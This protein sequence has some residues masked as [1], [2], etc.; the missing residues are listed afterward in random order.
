MLFPL[1]SQ[2]KLPRTH[3]RSSLKEQIR[4]DLL[5]LFS[6]YNCFNCN[7]K[8]KPD[9][10]AVTQKKKNKHTKESIKKKISIKKRLNNSRKLLKD[11]ILIEY[12]TFRSARRTTVSP[13]EIVIVKTLRKANHSINHCYYCLSAIVAGD[14]SPY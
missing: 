2:I 1:W 5:N 14:D 8:T 7:N 6:H 10:I 11:Q 9:E 13:T 12:S 3:L 4:N